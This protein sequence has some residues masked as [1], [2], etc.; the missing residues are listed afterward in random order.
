ML[1][2]SRADPGWEERIGR[3]VRDVPRP[4]DLD[5]RFA[6]RDRAGRTNLE[7][8][9]RA[10]FPAARLASTL[11][12]VY[13]AADGELVIPLTVRHSGLP[14]HPGE[15]SLPGGAVDPGDAS[16]EAT[17]LREAEEEVGVDPATVR[18]H[19]ALDDIWIPVSNFEIR[20]FVGTSSTRPELVPHT[21]EVAA[22]VELPV[23]VL[24]D[25]A[26]VTEEE[27]RVRGLILRAAVYRHAGHRI[28]GATARAL[29][30]FGAALERV[31]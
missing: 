18:I 25:A 6:P 17:A 4:I 7:R 31:A 29:A 28:W 12:L 5:P 9:D 2:G 1:R 27:I 22:M 20:P 26:L 11:L 21:E 3:A 15:V 30:M 23:A 8:S 10:G 13:P 16:R 19:G 24:L 14:A